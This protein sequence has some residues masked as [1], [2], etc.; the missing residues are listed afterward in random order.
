MSADLYI[1]FL[2][3][4]KGKT[5]KSQG[6]L[7]KIEF[8]VIRLLKLLLLSVNM[9]NVCLSAEHGRPRRGG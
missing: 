2:K 5:A 3:F 6:L 8:E 1:L 4:Q 7:F 9:P